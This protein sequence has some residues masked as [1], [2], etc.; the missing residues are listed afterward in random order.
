LGRQR[1]PATD[2]TVRI[3]WIEAQDQHESLAV[4]LRAVL[5]SFGVDRPYDEL[6]A[7]LGLGA[8][9]VAT[10]EDSLAWWHTHAR[11][12]R[13][14]ET[15]GLYGLRLRWLH[16]PEA[17]LGLGRSNEYAEHFRD[18]YVP[19][20]AGALANDQLALAWRGWPSPSDRLWGVITGTDGERVTG[21]TLWQEGRPCPLTGP[22]HQ[23]YIAERFQPLQ[24]HA[25]T[26]ANLFA[27]VIDQ[28]RAAWAG[29]WATGTSLK[30][31]AAAYNAWQEA[32]RSPGKDE[33]DAPPLH[34][35]HS[36]AVRVHVGAR[37]CLATWLRRIAGALT[38]E[39]ARLATRWADVCDRV[40]QQ[41]LPAESPDATKELLEQ[42]DG[43]DHICATIDAVC[44]TE[45]ALIKELEALNWRTDCAT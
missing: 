42:P 21:H 37:R 25:V 5:T 6:V 44:K 4:S 8:A 43:I 41:L 9:T 23:V 1:R 7:T 20:I 38:D 11:D 34:R 2:K 22:A 40:V 14:T 3:H 15:A 30:L 33:T 28:A 24:D 27:H 18:S 35:Q 17:V 26:Q 36:R 45:A 16:P 32:L 29:T 39:N 10:T 19:L 31:G 13:L 12:A